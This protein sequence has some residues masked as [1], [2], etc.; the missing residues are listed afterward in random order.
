MKLAEALAMRNGHQAHIQDLEQRLRRS[1]QVQM[2]DN[3]PENPED[4][5]S[6]MERT[7]QELQRLISAIDRTNSHATTEG[8]TL[9]ELLIE[10]NLLRSRQHIL[11]RLLAEA[12]I[13]TVR[14]TKSEIR[15]VTTIR[16]AQIQKDIDALGAEYRRLDM[17]LQAANWSIDLI[18]KETEPETSTPATES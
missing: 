10:R 17:M 14:Q 7:F 18:E 4:L 13:R 12:S 8:K 3:P 6:D 5:L 2:G 15:I 1:S 16:V 9:A 11:E